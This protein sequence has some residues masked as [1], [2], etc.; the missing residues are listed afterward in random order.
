MIKG[1]VRMSEENQ[2]EAMFEEGLDDVMLEEEQDEIKPEKD[3]KAEKKKPLAP[4][5][6]VYDFPNIMQFMCSQ[7]GASNPINVNIPGLKR[8]FQCGAAIH[9]PAALKK[10]EKTTETNDDE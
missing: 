3:K 10:T 4:T 9:V 8:C 5:T 7:C 2:D 1:G 6:P